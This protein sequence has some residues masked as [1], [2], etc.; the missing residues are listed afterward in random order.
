MSSEYIVS[1]TIRTDEDPS[2]ILASIEEWANDYTDDDCNDLVESTACVEDIT[3]YELVKSENDAREE[4]AHDERR[5]IAREE[6]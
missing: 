4:D 2:S 6:G 5:E 3:D 1:V